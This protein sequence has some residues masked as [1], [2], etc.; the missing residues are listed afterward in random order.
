MA[1]NAVLPGAASSS[2]AA[3]ARVGVEALTA[4]FLA[5]DGVIVAGVL[6]TAVV[7]FLLRSRAAG[8]LTPKLEPMKLKPE[9]GTTQEASL[10]AELKAAQQAYDEDELLRQ[11]E[12]ASLNDVPFMDGP[13]ACAYAWSV[14][15]HAQET[16]VSFFNLTGAVPGPSYVKKEDDDDAGPSGVKEQAKNSY[17]AFNPLYQ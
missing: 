14:F 8:L 17:W 5:L 16:G 12:A 7:L 1:G 10:Y 11:A 2:G 3:S 6:I 4:I 15:M 9:P 13:S